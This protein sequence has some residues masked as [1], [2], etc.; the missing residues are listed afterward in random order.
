ME[1]SLH[2]FTRLYSFFTQTLVARIQRLKFVGGLS[3]SCLKQ[4]S[5]SSCRSMQ[6]GRIVGRYDVTVTS[7]NR[8]KGTWHAPKCVVV[9]F[10][11]SCIRERLKHL[12]C[13]RLKKKIMRLQGRTNV[14]CKRP[15]NPEVLEPLCL[16]TSHAE[17]R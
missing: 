13:P 2:P 7:R 16:Y 10:S 9:V 5:K 12:P 14:V 4:I 3:L 1:I 17:F 11:Y 15:G 8:N 6:V